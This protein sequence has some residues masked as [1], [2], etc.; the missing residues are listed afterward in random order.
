MAC[1]C[2]PVPRR[3]V[4]GRRKLMFSGRLCSLVWEEDLDLSS[5]TRITRQVN[6]RWSPYSQRSSQDLVTDRKTKLL[7]GSNSNISLL[8]L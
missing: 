8:S 6:L 5:G 3:L 2:L 4:V 7:T 1:F